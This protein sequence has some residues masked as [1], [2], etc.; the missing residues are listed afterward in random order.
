MNSKIFQCLKNFRHIFSILLAGLLFTAS[1]SFVS[2]A[3][4][5][6]K[7]EQFSFSSYLNPLV[8]FAQKIS[9]GFGYKIALAE[10]TPCSDPTTDATASNNPNGFTSPSWNPAC[11]DNCGDDQLSCISNNPSSIML[12]W[13]PAPDPAGGTICA[14]E[15][16]HH[17]I[18]SLNPT[19]LPAHASSVFVSGNFAYVVFNNG[20]ESD[21]FRIIDVFNPIN[22]KIRG[23][24]NLGVDPKMT[25]NARAVYVFGNYAYVVFN[26]GKN[27]AFRIIDI[28]NPDNPFIVGGDTNMDTLPANARSI[29]VFRNTFDGNLYAYV[30]FDNSGANAFRIIDVANP[31]SPS[32]KGGNGLSALPGNGR[33]IFVTH[34]M[35]LL[36]GR[37]YAYI[38]FENTDSTKE[39]RI[40]NV[41]NPVSPS[42]SGGSLLTTLPNNA[43]SV[44]V[45]N[46]RAYLMF[47]TANGADTY[48]AIN[49]FI[50]NPGNGQIVFPFA[51]AG[52]PT[53]G[54]AVY[55][56]GNLAYSVFDHSSDVDANAFRI[57]DTTTN[58]IIST[59]IDNLTLPG[60]ASS[61]F[62]TG[63][64]AYVVFDRPA[65]FNEFRII[66]IADSVVPHLTRSFQVL[67]PTNSLT[68]NSWLDKDA[69][70]TWSVEAFYSNG[71]AGYDSAASC[72]YGNHPKGSIKIS[73]PAIP[74]PQPTNQTPV[75]VATISTDGVNYAK[76]IDVVQGVATSVYL[77][78]SKPDPATGKTSDDPDGWSDPVN[79]VRQGGKCEWNSNLDGAAAPIPPVF[80]QTITSPSSQQ[81][82]DIGPLKPDGTWGPGGK[83]TFLDSVGIH[84]Y[85][86]LRI[87]DKPGA[88]SNIDTVQVN[89][90][91]A[92]ALTVSIGGTSGKGRVT[93]DVPGLDNNIIDCGNGGT[94]CLESYA[95]STPV[96]LTAAADV[97]SD[98]VGWSG[99]DSTSGVLPN[100]KC[101]VTMNNSKSAQANFDYK[102]YTLTVVISPAGGGKVT[103]S[104][105]NCPGVCS[106]IY[107]YGANVNLSEIPNTGYGFN[108]WSGDCAGSGPA[109]SVSNMTT[110]LSVTANFNSIVGCT[111]KVYND[112]TQI[113]NDDTIS[114]AGVGK[115]KDFS[116]SSETGFADPAKVTWDITDSSIAKIDRHTPED[117]GAKITS[118]K[119]SG[120]INPIVVVTDRNV[121]DD[122]KVW[123]NIKVSALWWKEI[124]PF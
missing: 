7:P 12:K 50:A 6:Q 49:V 65:G 14:G 4:C 98:F 59:N 91:A 1:V 33:S 114:F 60:Y 11:F 74:P 36:G 94:D 46:N 2:A 28:S 61:V 66:N 18:A 75:A 90:Q 9:K 112:G 43:I 71:A 42:I 119:R 76:K 29:Y 106:V 96:V 21:N 84:A 97:S 22:P 81:K 20:S 32:V 56:V 113:N 26:S 31:A 118:K 77:A 73:C 37:D 35:S 51:P 80:D 117:G 27:N 99:C 121:G 62:V 38:A 105:V 10:N 70:Y 109:C 124:F 83:I 104:G 17:Y 39:F 8:S 53:Y 47:H 111:L 85:Q 92:P 52:S 48:R 23:G 100:Q 25:D 54:Q 103:G 68:L 24:A 69:V 57:I 87:T 15:A 30:V 88:Q 79:G 58:K 64:Y 41:G 72:G 95:P 44:A 93:S 67:A 63:N 13:E 122:C 16:L 116:V 78:A 5:G 115:E 102:K 34:S 120:A 40:I 107:N 86:V 3:S 108:N 110:N 45:S 55:V 82:C 19:D 123:F 101:N 89:V